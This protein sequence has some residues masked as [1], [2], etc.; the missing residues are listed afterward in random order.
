MSAAA[1]IAKVG[2]IARTAPGQKLSRPIRRFLHHRPAVI[3][4]TLILLYLLAALFAPA[5]APY[6]PLDMSAGPRLQSPSLEHLLGTD[7]FGRDI[8]SRVLFGARI[9]FTVSMIFPVVMAMCWTPA[10]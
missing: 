8:L 4:A 2:W 5:L 3:A 7:E 1:P 9:A 10:P 6:D